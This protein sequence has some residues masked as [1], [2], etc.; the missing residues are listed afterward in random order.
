MKRILTKLV[1]LPEV[2][3]EDSKETKSILFLT[4]SSNKKGA[5]CP[6]CGKTSRRLHQN[7]SHLVKDLPMGNK[8]VI[9]KVNRRQ[10]KCDNCQ[11]PF[12]EELDFV[13]KKRNYTKRYAENITEQVIHSDIHNVA[14]NNNL[15]DEQV[16]T[17]LK[18]QS[19]KNIPVQVDNLRTLGIDEISLVKGQGKYI[20]VLVDLDTHKLIGLVSSR[21]QLE[22]EKAMREW[23]ET[24]LVKIQEV[25]IDMSGNYKSLIQKLC[26]NAVI[27]VDRFHVTKM[28]HEE[29]NGART[30]QKKVAE[31]L[32]VKQRRKLFESLKGSK[33]TLLKAENKL[34]STQKEKLKIVK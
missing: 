12:S 5:D 34:S 6:R 27:T 2:I 23:G 18:E 31:T 21:T 20:V 25:S 29:L 24:V 32:E 15:T 1:D 26:P 28:I 17:M 4:V 19:Q 7:H 10:F 3:V 14:K 11:K 13:T 33:Y 30:N 16:W 9:L 8:E 22:I